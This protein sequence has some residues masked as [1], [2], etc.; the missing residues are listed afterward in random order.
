MQVSVET[1]K[2]LERKVTVSVPSAKI[3]EE[4]SL[5][6]KNLAKKVKVDGYRPGKVPTSVVVKRYSD[7]VRHE[8]ARDMIQ[9]TLFEALQKHDLNPA[10]FPNI[11]PQQVEENKDFIYVATLEVMPEF[12][13]AELNKA[14]VEL[15]KSEVT[16]K[17]VND[18][19]DKLRDQNKEW[20]E[21]NR[22]VKKNDKVKMDFEGFL[23]ETAFEGGSA[24]GYELVIGSGSM[25]PG[26]ED[27]VIGD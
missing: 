10:G 24:K 4:V 26:F 22:A 5:R 9:S 17:D 23:G 3:E 21:V 25:I 12:E 6:L 16:D 7:S 20:H 14:S 19:L 15:V 27:G 2:G 11:E 8:V 18:M 1:L 13:V